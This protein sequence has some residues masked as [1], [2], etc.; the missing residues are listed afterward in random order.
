MTTARI[1]DP[2]TDKTW[3]RRSGFEDRD[4]AW[5]WVLDEVRESWPEL[6]P[7]ARRFS[8]A[9]ADFHTAL[10]LRLDGAAGE[11][12]VSVKVTDDC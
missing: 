9:Y 2:A 11:D 5:V 4:E 6:L 1:Y 10:D 12:R 8:V 7:K 3:I